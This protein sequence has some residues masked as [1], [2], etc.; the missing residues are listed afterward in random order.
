[1]RI[2]LFINNKTFVESYAINYSYFYS[3]S[4]LLVWMTDI[5]ILTNFFFEYSAVCSLY[6]TFKSIFIK[7]LLIHFHTLHICIVRIS[8]GRFM[9]F[10]GRR[11]FRRVNYAAQNLGSSQNFFKI[12]EIEQKMLCIFLIFSSSYGME[13]ACLYNQAASVISPSVCL[14]VC[15]VKIASP[16]PMAESSPILHTVVPQVRCRVTRVTRVL[17]SKLELSYFC[18][19]EYSLI[20]K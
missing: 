2:W 16:T 6:W 11:I 4:V 18:L 19:L 12:C 15:L 20:N 7:Y 8:D 1:M 3:A 9:R 14:S 13:W 17:V 10:C 5:P